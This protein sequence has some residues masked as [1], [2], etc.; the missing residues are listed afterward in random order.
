MFGKK[1][2]VLLEAAE[3]KIK[4]QQDKL[5]WYQRHYEK[6][7]VYIE[8]LYDVV[9]ALSHQLGMVLK[10]ENMEP[11]QKSPYLEDNSKFFL[12]LYVLFSMRSKKGKNVSCYF[13]KGREEL[14][15]KFE[16]RDFK[17]SKIVYLTERLTLENLLSLIKSGLWRKSIEESLKS[18]RKER[19]LDINQQ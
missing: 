10:S 4:Q 1:N 3:A 2:A 14:Q 18:I 16:D 6:Q 11:L 15:R 13:G 8:E 5:D 17:N 7:Q 19:E 12:D 9:A